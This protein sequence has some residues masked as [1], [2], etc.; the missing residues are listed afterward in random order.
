MEFRRFLFRSPHRVEADRPS[1]NSCPARGVQ[2]G[3]HR[4]R[5][6]G[7]GFLPRDRPIAQLVRPDRRAGPRAQ[8]MVAGRDD[9]KAVRSILQ[10]G[11]AVAA[12]DQH[13]SLSIRRQVIGPVITAS[14]RAATPRSLARLQKSSPCP[15]LGAAGG[16][17][18]GGLVAAGGGASLSLT[19]PGTSPSAD[20]SRRCPAAPAFPPVVTIPPPPSPPLKPEGT[21]LDPQPQI[22][23]PFP[24]FS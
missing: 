14:P 5:G 16:D 20:C 1:S 23:A 22:R 12:G 8:H 6:A 15:R 17:L 2:C 7:I 24:S 10:T 18:R 4:Q 13:D 3:L 19:C 21:P 11:E 9:A